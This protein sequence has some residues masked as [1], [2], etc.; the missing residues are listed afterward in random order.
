MNN[1]ELLIKFMTIA[2]HNNIFDICCELKQFKKE[3]KTSDFYKTTKMPLNAAYKL[4]IETRGFMLY[5]KLNNWL[6]PEFLGDK[7]NEIIDS[8]SEEKLQDFMVRITQTFNLD[9][10]DIEK[11]ELKELINNLKILN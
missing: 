1:Q 5:N 9:N 4:F 10:L 8:I 6:E 2:N 3:Y 7:I 11:G